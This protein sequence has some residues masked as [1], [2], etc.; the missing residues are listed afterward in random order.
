MYNQKTVT[1]A[2]QHLPYPEQVSDVELVENGIRFTWRGDNFRLSLSSDLVEECV[3]DFE[4]ILR[5]SNIAIL[6]EALLRPFLKKE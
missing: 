2:L 4:P 6:M 3:N 1:E 5:G